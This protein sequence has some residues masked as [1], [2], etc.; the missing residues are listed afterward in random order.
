MAEEA[1]A[2]RR[3][4]KLT[5]YEKLIKLPN[6]VSQINIKK[7]PKSQGFQMFVKF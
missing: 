4:Y 3:F 2:V 6:K 7:F 5:V 1:L